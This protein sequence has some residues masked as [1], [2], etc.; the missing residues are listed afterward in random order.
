ML[1]VKYSEVLPT[2]TSGDGRCPHLP[3]VREGGHAEQRQEGEAVLFRQMPDGVVERAPVGDEQKSILHAGMP[4]VREGVCEL[5]EPGK[6]V[7]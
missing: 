2:E 5:W 6:E 3:A 1:A 4:A 7:L